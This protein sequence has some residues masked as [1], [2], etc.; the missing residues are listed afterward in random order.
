MPFG[1][2]KVA[3]DSKGREYVIYNK[4]TGKVKGRSHTRELAE[5]SARAANA[6]S[7]DWKPS[8]KR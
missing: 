1:V 8:R 4:E 3:P 7:H 2:K 6:G 5:A